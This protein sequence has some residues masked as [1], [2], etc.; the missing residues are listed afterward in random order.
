MQNK[1]SVRGTQVLDQ[2]RPA[3]HDDLSVEAGDRRIINREII[4]IVAPQGIRTRL[5]RKLVPLGCA[6][7]DD[8]FGHK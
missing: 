1:R 7:M 8:Q 3:V 6:G 5:E 4:G 2:D